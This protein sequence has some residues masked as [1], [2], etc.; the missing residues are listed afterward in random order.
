[1]GCRIYLEELDAAA[2]DAGPVEMILNRGRGSGCKG[3]TQYAVPGLLL[4]TPSKLVIRFAA[5]LNRTPGGI[6]P[7]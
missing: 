4:P 2:A 1:L 5:C 6:T 3:V 7:S